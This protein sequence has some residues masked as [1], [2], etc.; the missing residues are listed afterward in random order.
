MLEGQNEGVLPVGKISADLA[1]N[2]SDFFINKIE[3]IRNDITYKYKSNVNNV[4]LGSDADSSIDRLEEFAPATMSQIKKA[5]E[6]SPNKSC[7]WLLNSCL[8]ELLPIF[9]KTVNTSPEPA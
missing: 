7:T 6:S 3:N 2:F 4:K 5:I 9:T 8:H 1:Q